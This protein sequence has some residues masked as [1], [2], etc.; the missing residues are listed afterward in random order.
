LSE[1]VN[2]TGVRKNNIIYRVCREGRGQNPVAKTD[3]IM[4]GEGTERR[5]TEIT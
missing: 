3:R 1:N 5:N 2:L 4:M